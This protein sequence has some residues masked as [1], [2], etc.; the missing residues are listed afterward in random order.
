[1]VF[2]L[3]ESPIIDLV[4][5]VIFMAF[6]IWWLRGFVE[7]EISKF[8]HKYGIGSDMEDIESELHDLSKR[9]KKIEDSLGKKK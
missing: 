4:V 6:L 5:V 3:L 2:N 1:M 9:I 7:D 8:F